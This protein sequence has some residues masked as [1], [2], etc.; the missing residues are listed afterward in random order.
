MNKGTTPGSVSGPCLLNIIINDLHT[1]PASNPL[2]FKD[3]DDSTLIFL[4]GRK[5]IVILQ[6]I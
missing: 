1:D 5:V 2:L 4:F 3:A 6:F